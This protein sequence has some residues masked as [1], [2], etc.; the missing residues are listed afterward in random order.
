[1]EFEVV[2]GPFIND[3]VSKSEMFDNLPSFVI[4]LSFVDAFPPLFN[5]VVYG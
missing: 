4:Y 5:E 1:M 3:V 2:V